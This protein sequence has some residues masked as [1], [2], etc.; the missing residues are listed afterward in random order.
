MILTLLLVLC[1]ALSKETGI[2]AVALCLAYELLIHRKVYIVQNE[3]DIKNPLIDL[4]Y[5]STLVMCTK[6]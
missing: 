5:S 3:A 6:L 1:S 2:T 4:I